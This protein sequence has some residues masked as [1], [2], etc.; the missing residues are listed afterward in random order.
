MR[1]GHL[2]ITGAAAHIV[3]ATRAKGFLHAA[4]DVLLLYSAQNPHCKS[5]NDVYLEA[6]LATWLKR[7]RKVECFSWFM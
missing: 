5:G 4:A 3:P 6:Y 1:Q 7:I 2:F